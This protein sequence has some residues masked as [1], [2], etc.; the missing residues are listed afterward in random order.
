MILYAKKDLCLVMEILGLR[1]HKSSTSYLL[2]Q[3]TS[4]CFQFQT[5]ST[6]AVFSCCINKMSFQFSLQPITGGEISFLPRN[7]TRSLSAV[8]EMPNTAR[9]LQMRWKTLKQ[10]LETTGFTVELEKEIKLLEEEVEEQTDKISR[11][12]LQEVTFHD[13]SY[14]L[15]FFFQIRKKLEALGTNKKRKQ[16]TVDNKEIS[17]YDSE[18]EKVKHIKVY[19]VLYCIFNEHE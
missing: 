14:Q 17:E 3:L 10:Q 12:L 19:F 18:S 16:S 8:K 2:M 9:S 5:M 11:D 15:Y 4:M 6:K 1:K 13:K 7:T